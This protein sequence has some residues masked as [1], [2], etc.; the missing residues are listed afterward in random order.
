MAKRRAEDTLLHGSPPKRYCRSLCSG[1]MQPK[2]MAETG[3][4]SPP[5]LL[6]LLGSRC[7]KRPYYFEDQEKPEHADSRLR[8]A[9]CEPREQA[10]NV[11]TV[12]VSG[13]FLDRRSSLTVT[14]KKRPREGS[15]GSE[16]VI[17]TVNNKT[18]EDSHSEDGTYNSFQYWRV[19][20]P[21]LDLS[22][23]GDDRDYSQ[24]KEKSKA[25]GSSSDAMET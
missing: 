2:S 21:E 16:T 17:P 11:L 24:T 7:R 20:L 3:G 12:P 14:S 23:L 5:S 6:E 19:P 22:L 1:N 18:Q 25:S 4:V 9:L 8:R 15:L 13:S 10:A